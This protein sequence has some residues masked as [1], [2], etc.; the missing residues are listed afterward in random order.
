MKKSLP[1]ISGLL[2]TGAFIPTAPNRPLADIPS[3]I[4]N[5]AL[6]PSQENAENSPTEFQS[7]NNIRSTVELDVN[8]ID[9]NPL[10][11]REVYTPEMILN[12]AEDLRSQGQH[13]PIHVIPNP[14]ATGRFVICDG[15]TRVQACRVHK[16]K[17]TLLAE[18]HSELSLQES[19]WF[20]YEQNEGRQQ[21][22]DLDRAMFFEKLIRDG[23]SQT[24]VSRRAKLSKSMMTFYRAYSQLP[25]DVLQIIRAYPSK[26]GATQAYYLLKLHNSLGIRKTVALAGKYSAEDQ[27]HRWLVNQ[28]QALLNPSNKEKIPGKTIKYKNGTYKQSGD[29]FQLSITVPSEQREAFA[30]GL[31]KLLET[32]T[33]AVEDRK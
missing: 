4:K 23:V 12:R 25:D 28:V 16:V 5:K 22:C 2:K 21:H 19:A 15:W 13:D 3:F 1:K 31:E 20:G 33:V 6:T 8:L 7:N 10:A 27:T 17:D 30:Q 11:P 26:F 32:A 14:E 29:L 9:P 24:E 18:I